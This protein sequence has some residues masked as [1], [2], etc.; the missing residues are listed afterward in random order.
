MFVVAAIRCSEDV[1]SFNQFLV[2]ICEH[3]HVDQTEC[4]ASSVSFPSIFLAFSMEISSHLHGRGRE[5][6]RAIYPHTQSSGGFCQY[7][8]TDAKLLCGPIPYPMSK[9]HLRFS[10]TI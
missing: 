5:T 2:Y 10:I 8:N 7:G 4:S 9:I 3:V 1:P 6:H